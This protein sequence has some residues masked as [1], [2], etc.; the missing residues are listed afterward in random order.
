MLRDDWHTLEAEKAAD[1]LKSNFNTGLSSGEAQARIKKFGH[2]KLAEGEKIKAYE[3]FFNQFKDFMVL[4]LLAA[5]VVSGVLGEIADTIAIVIIIVL[6]AVLGFVQEFKAEKS[7]ASLKKM[8]APKASVLRGRKE[9]KIAAEDLVPGD[10]ILL[11]AGDIVPADARLIES[12][13]LEVDESMLTGES[14]PVK[15]EGDRCCRRESTIGD[16][17]NLLYSGT[18]VTAGRAKGL[19]TATGM[20]TEIGQ[21]AAMIQKVNDDA[22]PLQKKLAQL[23]KI[24]IVLCLAVC[25]LV[26]FLGVLRGEDFGVM[27]LTGVSLAVAAIPEG[28]PAIVTVV[29]A[30]GVQRM[31]K[32]QA[33]VKKL[34]SVETL[35]CAS[36]ICSDKTGTL[37]QNV[38]NVK[39]IYCSSRFI[40]VSGFGYV[41]A[42]R[43]TVRDAVIEPTE[44]E[45]LRL[46]LET[47]AVC[48]NVILKKGDF[49]LSS[50]WRKKENTEWQ[51]S[52][53]PTEGALAVAAAK[54]GIWRE[55]SGQTRIEEIPFDSVR[56]MMSV[57]CENDKG[58]YTAYVKGALDVILP[59][60]TRI[61]QNGRIVR[62]DQ[63][64]REEILFANAKMASSALRVLGLAYRPLKES[65][66]AED[67]LIFLGL[68]GLI[69]PPR[70]E[71]KEAIKVCQKAGI[72][73]VMVTGD[74]ALTAAAIA[75]E[76]GILAE[77][78][79]VMT[80]EELEKY[81]DDSLAKR[82]D[83]IGV[84]ARVSPQHKLMIVKAW[85]KR[86]DVVAMTGD[87]VNDAP[88]VK[89]ADIGVAM[90]R[91]G[92]DVTKESS[93]L[94][95]MDDNFATIVAA[96]EEGRAI[97]NNIRKFI[98]Y[99]LGC[100]IGEILTMLLASLLGF[101]LP[102]LPIQILLINLVTDG[103]P[104]LALGVEPAE[105]N[106]MLFSPRSKKKNI[107]AD[108]LGKRIISRGL[109]IGISTIA[110]F[111]LALEMTDGDLEIARTMTFATL[112]MSQ[113]CF[114]FT[115]RSEKQT[116][117]QLGLFT[118]PY[119]TGAVL[120]SVC[121]LL[122]AV[123]LP[124]LQIFLVTRSLAC[125][126]WLII[127]AF[128]ALPLLGQL[129]GIRVNYGSKTLDC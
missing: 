34:P 88:A 60:C 111:A 91:S 128:S 69:D 24:L 116:V 104:A 73:T 85:K 114:V 36:V 76:L 87:G 89:E 14:L 52:G 27:F 8:T 64:R 99:L 126:Q 31:V 17:V 56:K 44:D 16:R 25:A 61:M 47:A 62:L 48:N 123:Y 108:G 40:D 53:D 124:Y 11:E 4:V 1:L 28:L 100:N 20:R 71:V 95:L 80:G 59:Y 102:L 45:S 33:V 12:S 42:G 90:G 92:T 118:N 97:Y 35:G 54:A 68:M 41:P 101:P 29:L 23:G 94:V 37:T 79:E 98:T 129:R 15:K 26:T 120:V 72:R 65:R 55:K 110:V 43:F 66:I 84:Y 38:M 86:G 6:N 75:R 3:I 107:F 74:H 51:I 18:V 77:G 5:A 7:L 13:R 57:L 67:D 125:W 2:N 119:L 117:F 122:I 109:Q 78:Q 106:I 49:S 82:V 105:K 32:R 93:S 96:V 58:E 83:K 21:I 22:T 112:V 115:C 10:L 103:L 81:D 39:K 70:E 9:L 121:T 30:I 127:L 113:L 19:V 63:K 50:L 46:L